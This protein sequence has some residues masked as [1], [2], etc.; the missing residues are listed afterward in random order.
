MKRKCK[1]KD[2]VNRKGIIYRL[3]PTNEQKVYFSK[4]FGCCRKIWNLMLFDKEE[5]YQ[6]TGKILNN[7]PAQYKQDYPFLKEVDSLGLANVKLDLERAFIS[8]FRKI[9]KKPKYKSAKHDKKSYTTNNQHGTVCIGNG[10]IR[11]PKIGL[12]RCKIHRQP[13]QDWTLKSATISMD[14]CGNYYV[15][16]LFEFA[17]IKDVD[18]NKLKQTD[19]IIGLDYKSDGLYM[20]SEGYSPK[21]KK[22][23]HDAQRRLKKLQKKLSHRIETHIIG[24]GV[25]HKPIFD[26]KL[27]ECKNI[28]KLRKKVAKLSCHVANQRKDFLHKESTAITKQYDVVCVEDLNMKSLANKGFH[29]GKATLDN[30]YGMFLNMLQYK[31]HD[32]G[33][34]L[35][36]VSRFYPSSQICHCCG[37]RNPKVKDLHIR[38]WVCPRCGTEHDR[39]VNAAIN[40]RNEGLRLLQLM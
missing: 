7:T 14:K 36:K 16:V 4:N 19:T 33:K 10:Y 37:E 9:T 32:N 18:I 13:K 38:K 34:L 24:Y 1:V 30:G 8:Y 40:I 27:E 29:N 6:N 26:K 22:Y 31:L 2:N 25:K 39:D 20:N 15:S 11:L 3:Y 35:V 12:V 17:K 5:Y 28:E 23:Y 21:M